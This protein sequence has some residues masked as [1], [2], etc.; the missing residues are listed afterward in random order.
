MVKFMSGRRDKI[1]HLPVNMIGGIPLRMTNGKKQDF[2]R[3]FKLEER[4]VNDGGMGFESTVWVQRILN[5][6]H[7]GKTFAQIFYI[8]GVY[9]SESLA[10]AARSVEIDG[11]GR[12]KYYDLKSYDICE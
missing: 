1:I 6:D 10:M 11:Y 12:K 8:E 4:D 3:D 7:G 2:N 9:G 5:D